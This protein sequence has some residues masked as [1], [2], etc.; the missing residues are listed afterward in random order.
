VV[1]K[2]YI[3]VIDQGTTS[4][5]CIIFDREANM[6]SSEYAEHEQI[7]PQAGWV[8][9]DPNEILE[10]TRFVTKR[11]IEAA[12]IQG[13]QIAAIGV[14]NQRETT[15]L[16]DKMTGQPVY[17][18]IVWQDTRTKSRCAA[19]RE[20][21]AADSLIRLKTGL[22]AH[23]YFSSSKIEWV[24]KNVP[25]AYEK[26]KKGTLL[27]G[28]IDT[29][30]IWNLTRGAPNN[31][32]P[33]RNG[34]HLT[35]YTNASRT[36]LFDIQRL[37]WSPDL[38][39][40]FGIPPEIMPQ[41]RPSSDRQSFGYTSAAG[42]FG[43]EVPIYGDLGDQQAALVG[44]ACFDPGEAKNTYGTGC[45]LLANLGDRPRF[46]QRGL[47]TTIAFG[48]EEAHCAY[49]FE[50]SVAIAGAAVQWLRDNLKL[51]TSSAET[52]T[53]AKS[54]SMTGSGGVYF[55]PAFSGLFVPYWDTDARGIMTGLTR[56]T[57]KEHLV[58]ATLE[59]ICWQTRDVYDA[60]T[61]EMQAKGKALKVDGGAARNDYLMQLQAD[62][63]GIEVIRPVVTETTALGAAYAAGLPV[64]FWPS[65]EHLR[66]IC[67]VDRVFIPKWDEEKRSKLHDGWSAA[68]KRSMG[69]LKE[70]GDLP[71]SGTAIN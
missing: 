66:E 62:I 71:P 24:M 6:V 43:Y 69:W 67:K 29:W 10:K 33:E 7:Y 28:N 41:A 40:M 18:A 49:A 52:E 53:L 39:Q 50:G 48:F 16:W 3:A 63:L 65:K 8:E 15:V 4:T 58:H 42:P 57:R 23:P 27:F 51:I 45:F 34:A 44:Q 64:D 2:K 61:E 54:V 25:A 32:T 13:K 26:A 11:S 1:E 9:H 30:I 22:Y 12:G 38:L 35:D 5:R 70:V 56:Y 37:E 55:V 59:S 14:T 20:N 21:N 31:P 47:L 60:M 36:M 68:V 46:S 17:N 19:T